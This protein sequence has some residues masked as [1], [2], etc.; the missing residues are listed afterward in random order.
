[1]ACLTLGA[2]AVAIA[3]CSSNGAKRALNPARPTA[4][5]TP[6]MGTTTSTA[7]LP[8]SSTTTA[9]SPTTAASSTTSVPVVSVAA[10]SALR[11]GAWSPIGLIVNGTPTLTATLL[12]GRPGGPL[13]GVARINAAVARPV[14]YAGAVEPGGSWPNQRAVTAAEL[15][16][17]VAAFNSGFH[18]YASAGGWFDHGRSAV[19]L[20]AG[21]ASLVIRADGSATVGLW[22]RDV[23]LTLDVV[24]VRQ[25]L[26]LLVDGGANLSGAGSWG[27]TL[28]NVRDTWRSGLGV[29]AA[30]SLLYAAGPGLDAFSLAQVLIQAGAVRA[31]ELDINPAFV[32][33]A[34][35]AAQGSAG[36]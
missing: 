10:T 22:G 4:T 24:S 27:A 25:N 32:G 13:T 9:P 14:L 17:L 3:G 1:M 11:A 29:D 21:A 26:G 2:V 20:R 35:Y 23:S 19:P 16:G 30:G 33:F 8:A 28:H 7:A 34:Y 15:P 6:L 5:T 36:T 31:M 12:Q 18:T